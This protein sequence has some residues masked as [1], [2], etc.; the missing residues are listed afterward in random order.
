MHKDTREPVAL[1]TVL[2]DAPDRDWSRTSSAAM[3]GCPPSCTRPPQTSLQLSQLKKSDFQ[4]KKLM[5]KASLYCLCPRPQD[6]GQR[7]QESLVQR[8]EKLQLLSVVQR[9]VS[10]LLSRSNFAQV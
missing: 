4:R 6:A 1:S 9:W 10:T 5:Q 8:R 3:P 2:D 7:L